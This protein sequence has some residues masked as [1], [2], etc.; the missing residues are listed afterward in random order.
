[1]IIT[2]SLNEALE[3]LHNGGV[4]AYPTETFYG[5]G[6]S[7]FNINAIERIYK[8]KERSK[9]Q[10]LP[11]IVRDYEQVLEIAHLDTD[12]ANSLQDLTSLFWPT[13]LSFL[14]KARKNISPLITADTGKIVV[15]QSPHSICQELVTALNAP[16]ISTSAN[17]SGEKPAQCIEEI[18]KD[19]NIDAILQAGEK[20]QGGLPS[21]IL[22]ILPKRKVRLIRQ[23]AF[24]TSIIAKLGYILE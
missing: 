4:I 24:D 22:E 18:S 11:L 16:I 12:K 15:R 7:I 14:V 5:I 9:S 10:A 6:A 13:S 2:N 21:T 20:P 23:G 3:I 1:M 19:L 17:K 8:I